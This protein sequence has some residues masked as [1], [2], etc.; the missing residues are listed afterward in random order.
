MDHGL[1]HVVAEAGQP[2]MLC[3]TKTQASLQ[4]AF[5]N[6]IQSEVVFQSPTPS[7][8]DPT[9]DISDQSRHI[10]KDLRLLT[11]GRSAAEFPTTLAYAAV[12]MRAASGRLLGIF[13]VIDSA[14]RHDFA[15]HQTYSILSDIAWA[16]LSHVESEIAQCDNNNHDMQAKSDLSTFLEH[17]RPQHARHLDSSRLPPTVVRS[18]T[19]NSRRI[20]TSATSSSSDATSLTRSLDQIATSDAGTPLTTPAEDASPSYFV[21]PPSIPPSTNKDHIHQPEDASAKSDRHR[22]QKTL[23]SAAGLIRAAHQLEGL[24]ILSTTSNSTDN[25]HDPSDDSMPHQSSL[26]EKLVTSIVANTNTPARI[27]LSMSVEHESLHYL[28]SQYPQGCVLKI[29]DQGVTALISMGISRTGPA[30][31]E[32]LNEPSAIPSDLQSLLE[33]AQSLVFMPLWDSAR[34]AFYAGLLGWPSNPIRVF[35][36][37]DLLSMSIYGRILTAEVT[38]FGE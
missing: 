28:I 35:T 30:Q 36:E 33:K 26:C 16:I 11:D 19:S 12:P 17:N 24:V 5:L 22:A 8:H 15:S 7:T 13:A 29:G 6:R 9:N 37:H 18:L 1:P 21:K 20:S 31:Y 34:Q 2:T 25:T 27:A 38:H 14:P 4:Q 32:G 23:S 10:V 3:A